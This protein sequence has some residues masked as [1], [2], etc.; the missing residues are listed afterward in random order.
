MVRQ[1]ILRL[2][3][4]RKTKYVFLNVANHEIIEMLILS[5]RSDDLT[6]EFY[7]KSIHHYNYCYYNIINYYRVNTFF[8]IQINNKSC[9][10]SILIKIVYL[11][12][13]NLII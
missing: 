4:M 6:A 11:N 10:F 2:Q 8:N 5:H 1:L 12:Y 7:C 13:L 3:I 9:S